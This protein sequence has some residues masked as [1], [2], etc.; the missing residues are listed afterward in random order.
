MLG[1]VVAIPTDVYA[2]VKYNSSLSSLPYD[3]DAFG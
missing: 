2:S 1:L 3:N